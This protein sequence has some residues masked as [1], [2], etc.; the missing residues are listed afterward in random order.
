MTDTLVQSGDVLLVHITLAFADGTVAD[1]TRANGE[2]VLLQLG[3]D[4]ISKAF[5]AQLIGQE[6]GANL[7][8]NLEPVDA[9]GE[10]NTDQ[11]QFFEAYQFAE[12]DLELD[13]IMLFEKPDG[14]QLPGVIKAI[15]GSS[16]KVDFNHPLAGEVVNFDIEILAI[17]PKVEQQEQIQIKSLT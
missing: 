10:S 5:E 12:Q 7:N 6:Q 16:V 9:F 15:E 14:S 11:I 2:P 13:T 1:S 17:N 3:N 4:S 8:F